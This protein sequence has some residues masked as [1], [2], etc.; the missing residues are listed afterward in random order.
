MSR[1]GVLALQGAFIEHVY[2]LRSLGVD[3]VEVR[4]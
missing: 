4:L 3:A 1:I 2:V